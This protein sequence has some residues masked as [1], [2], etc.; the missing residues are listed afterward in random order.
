MKRRWQQTVDR[1][2]SGVEEQLRAFEYTI[3]ALLAVAAGIFALWQYFGHLEDARIERSL[4]FYKQF[5][6]EPLYS[7]RERTLENAEQLWKELGRIHTGSTPKELREERRKWQEIVVASI[8]GK[9]NLS[10]DIGNL[11]T[12]FDALQVCAENG[13]CDS[14]TAHELLGDQ[15][16]QF[17]ENYCP[18]IAYVHYIR[19]SKTFAAKAIEFSGNAC[20]VG[21]YK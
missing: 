13:V 6:T 7:A 8:R 9:E 17:V 21:I 10:A 19:N 18:Y 14:K 3:K 11:V 4:Q 15:A 5:S 16:K 20:H 1:R 12:Y 2:R